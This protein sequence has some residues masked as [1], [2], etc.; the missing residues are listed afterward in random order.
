MPQAGG[1]RTRDRRRGGV[2]ALDHKRGSLGAVGVV[3]FFEQF[4][5]TRHGSRRAG[6]QGKEL[7]F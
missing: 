6:T 4:F 2:V 5:D 3:Q 7:A 1:D